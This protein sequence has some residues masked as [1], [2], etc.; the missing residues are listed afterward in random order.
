MTL[1]RTDLANQDFDRVAGH[2]AGRDPLYAAGYERGYAASQDLNRHERNALAV[3]NDKLRAVACDT[4][5]TTRLEVI[6]ENG[7]RIVRYAGNIRL[8]LQDDGLTL[9]VFM[10]GRD[11]A[12][13]DRHVR[14]LA[15]VFEMIDRGELFV[16][17]VRPQLERIAKA[18]GL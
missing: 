9:K 15:E 3:E 4:S 17:D 10:T 12:A 8:S 11:Q 13:I 14:A 5:R 2:V 1:E 7:K 6:D 16:E 18:A